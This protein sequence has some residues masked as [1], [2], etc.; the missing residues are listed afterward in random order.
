[1]KIGDKIH[2]SGYPDKHGTITSTQFSNQ[3]RYDVTWDTKKQAKRTCNFG[4]ALCQCTDRHCEE[5]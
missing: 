1:M 5:P 4:E 3:N 2:L